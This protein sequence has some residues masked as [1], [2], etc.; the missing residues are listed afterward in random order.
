MITINYPED[1]IRNIIDHPDKL[2][3]QVIFKPFHASEFE[4]DKKNTT[5]SKNKKRGLDYYSALIN[6]IKFIICILVAV[7]AYV[8]S[9]REIFCKNF[10]ENILEI[11]NYSLTSYLAIFGGC[12]TAFSIFIAFINKEA[13]LKLIA[14][15]KR[16]SK[17]DLTRLE[18]IILY[19]LSIIFWS[20]LIIFINFLIKVIFIYVPVIEFITPILF[21]I[22]IFINFNILLELCAFLLNLYSVIMIIIYARVTAED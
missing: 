13:I 16:F 17:N 19:F 1:L 6:L 18:N 20:I 22:Y 9:T 21:A 15:D 8:I 7:V 3:L 11:S 4:N 12:I 5:K 14:I 10:T 2:I